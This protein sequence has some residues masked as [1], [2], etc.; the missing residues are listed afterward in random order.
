MNADFLKTRQTKFTAFATVYVLI[1]IGALGLLNWLAQR[2]NKSVDTTS[3]KKFSLSD[4]TKKVVGGLKDDVKITYFD[5]SSNYGSAK[6]LLDRYETLSPKLTV[7]YVDPEKKPQVAKMY[8]VRNYG[9]TF[10]TASGRQQEAKSVSEEEVTGALIRAMKGTE[11]SACVV[12]GSGEHGLDDAGREGYAKFKETLDRNNYKTRVISLL[13]K[14]VV[15]KDCTVLIVGGPRFDYPQPVADAIKT[16]VEGGGH[17]LILID[18]PLKLGKQ[19]IAENA[20]LTSVLESW[21]VTADKD[22]VLDLSG[23]GQMFGFNAAVPLVAS[24]DNHPIVRD[25][26][27]TATAFPLAR[28]LTVKS[29]GK[30][31]VDKLFSTSEN[32][33]ATTDLSSGE[34]KPNPGKDK[35]GPLVL[36]AAGTYQSNPQ[37]RFVVVGSSAFVGNGI[38]G[39][40]GNR[41]LA[42]NMLNWLSSDE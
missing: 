7:E 40:N 35:P 20:P 41:D 24:Y 15:P 32:S 22:L 16:Y 8:G 21:G 13:D 29:A 10:V 38:L 1:V 27:G 23:V 5:R 17:A 14:P 2:H 11:R 30:S 39:F 42:M 3:T 33:F 36:G 12:S 26:K 19:A 18:P 31:N 9:A 34:I 6:D 37:G 4:Q 25:M 28:S